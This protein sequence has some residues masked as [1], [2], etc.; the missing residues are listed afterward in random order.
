MHLNFNTK[1]RRWGIR[2][3]I[4][5][6]LLAALGWFL[7]P[8]AISLPQ[9]LRQDPVTSPVLLDRHGSVIQHLTLRVKSL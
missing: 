8:F 4:G 1:W 2:S 9:G 6:A 5:V 7:L 3:V